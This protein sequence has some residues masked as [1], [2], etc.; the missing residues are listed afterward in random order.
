MALLARAFGTFWV[1]MTDAV[2]L[3]SH[4]DLVAALNLHAGGAFRG[5]ATGEIEIVGGFCGKIGCL[6]GKSP[7]FLRFV[8]QFHGFDAHE[9]VLLTRLVDAHPVNAFRSGSSC[10]DLPPN[11][12]RPRSG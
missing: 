12:R 11:C 4:H 8:A 3:L 6:S 9:G 10:R 2:V 7:L 1:K 5:F